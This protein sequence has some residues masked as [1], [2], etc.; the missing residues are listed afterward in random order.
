MTK[1]RSNNILNIY[2]DKGSNLSTSSRRRIT[3]VSCFVLAFILLFNRIFDHLSSS[4][5]SSSKIDLH[6]HKCRLKQAISSG[7]CQ[8]FSHRSY[9]NAQTQDCQT[10][11]KHLKRIGVNHIDLDL[12]LTDTNNNNNIIDNDH[13]AP[14]NSLIVAHPME[15]KHT[16]KTYSPCGN[17]PFNEMIHLLKTVYNDNNFF[18]S[19]EPKAAWGQTPQELNDVALIN[20]PSRI[21]Q[22]LLELVEWNELAGHCAV[23]VELNS[24]V[25]RK[26]EAEFRRQEE[27]MRRLTQHCQ[28]FKGIRLADNVHNLQ[29]DEHD[30]IMPTIEFHPR[31]PHNVENKEMPNG[32]WSKSIVWVV[33]NEKDLEFAAELSPRGIVSNDPKE[34]VKILDRW[35]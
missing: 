13:S 14:N 31:H 27:L 4:S 22:V 18:I 5:S 3:L 2:S 8:L 28:W 9:Y 15:Y 1:N 32:L 16:T 26:D 19:M 33:D 17:T 6:E 11:L 10:A 7:E 24:D 21:L 34:I 23:I 20:P 35:C 30:A 25:W 29:M 12:V